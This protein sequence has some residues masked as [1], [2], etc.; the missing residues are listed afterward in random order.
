MV[1]RLCWWLV[2]QHGGQLGH[3]SPIKWWLGITLHDNKC[4]HFFVFVILDQ[5]FYFFLTLVH[6][7]VDKKFL[8]QEPQSLN[9]FLYLQPPTSSKNVPPKSAK[10]TQEIDTKNTQLTH[11]PDFQPRRVLHQANVPPHMKCASNHGCRGWNIKG[12]GQELWLNF[13]TQK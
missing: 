11:L 6:S 2:A 8:T 10:S 7:L 12:L 5:A 1:G 9:M 13:K 4:D 3:L